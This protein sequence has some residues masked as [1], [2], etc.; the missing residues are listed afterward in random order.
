MR[1][2]RWKK[3]LTLSILALLAAGAV[4]AA[5]PRLLGSFRDWNAF[6]LQEA[7]GPV[8]W[9]V[10]RP[11]RQEGDFT[12]RGDVFLLIIHR[13]AENSLDVVNY[14]AGY[15]F[16]ERSEALLQIAGK[17]YKLFVEGEGAWARD[18]AL[19]HSISQ[20]LRNGTL[21]TARGTSA[22]GSRVTDTF[23]LAGATA[24]YQAI[25]AACGVP[26]GR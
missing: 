1:A 3:W 14:I 12:K 22:R 19:D 15:P 17:S 10:S 2:A 24:A 6:M 25:N 16:E 26:E 4:Q 23:S 8:C 21:M 13:P 18:A 11:K 20:A 9:M 5:E 7:A